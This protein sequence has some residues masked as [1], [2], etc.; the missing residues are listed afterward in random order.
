MS[1]HF[2][3]RIKAQKTLGK[4]DNLKFSPILHGRAQVHCHVI[5]KSLLDHFME[6]GVLKDS[7]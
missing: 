1:G 7:C 3:T 4:G 2:L 5:T 6:R